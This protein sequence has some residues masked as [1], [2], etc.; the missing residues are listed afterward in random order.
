[1]TG[2]EHAAEQPHRTLNSRELARAA[3]LALVLDEVELPDGSRHEYRW[4]RATSAA[5]VVPV[6]DDLSTVL[7]RQWRYPWRETSWE[8]PA[9]TLEEGEDPLQC[10]RRELEEEAGV[11]ASRW[12]PLGE[13]RP[14]A[15]MDSRQYLFLARD[16]AGTARAPE[17]YEGDMI[18]RRLPLRDA[19][20]AALGGE[21]THA[22]A[23]SALCRAG[24][25][26]GLL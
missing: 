24:R 3:R 13:L 21:I 15:L 2:L 5:F 19:V 6:F 25:K 4:L 14:S 11:R 26:L 23:V 22:T 8:V 20:E 17:A 16:L 9:G 1:M 7:V 10:A 12:E 18:V